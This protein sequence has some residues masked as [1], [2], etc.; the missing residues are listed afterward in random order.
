[1]P[2]QNTAELWETVAGAV[3]ASEIGDLTVARA[4]LDSLRSR[5]EQPRHVTSDDEGVPARIDCAGADAERDDLY[6]QVEQLEQELERMRTLVE[7]WSATAFAARAK[8][9]KQEAALRHITDGIDFNPTLGNDGGDVDRLYGFIGGIR[10]II[11]SRALA[12][13]A[14]LGDNEKP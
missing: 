1:M 3:D 2:E 6:R 11:R 5:M 9:E 7:Q 14:A 12:A 10:D 8:V 4:A 13:L